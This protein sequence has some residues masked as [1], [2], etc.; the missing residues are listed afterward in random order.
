[1]LLL[2]AVGALL[3]AVCAVDALSIGGRRMKVNVDTRDVA[4][5]AQTLVTFD[6]VPISRKQRWQ[7]YD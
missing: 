7:P 1:M 4:A 5:A 6:E 2:K 3:A